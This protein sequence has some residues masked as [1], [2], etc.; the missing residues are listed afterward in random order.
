[1]RS[2]PSVLESCVGSLGHV[3]VA[4]HFVYP[5]SFLV[6]SLVDDSLGCWQAMIINREYKN[7]I[8]QPYF[9][10]RLLACLPTVSHILLMHTCGDGDYEAILLTVLPMIARD[11][12]GNA[13]HHH[14]DNGIICNYQ[15]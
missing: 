3:A 15:H 1:M 2:I 13:H 5:W 7:S 8:E 14:H 6:V 12:M 9:E 10:S 4:V 11:S